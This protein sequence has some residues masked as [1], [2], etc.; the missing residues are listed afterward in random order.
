MSVQTAHRLQVTPSF[1]WNYLL[2]QPGNLASQARWPLLLFL[3]GSG[4]RG[5]DLELVKM[6]GLP[7]YIE[8]G[9]HFPFIIASPQ[10]PSDTRW[11]DHDAALVALLESLLTTLPVDVGRMYLTG[12][13]MGGE[14]TWYF[15]ALHPELFSAIAPICGR[16]PERSGWPGAVCSLIGVPVWC[17]HGMKD[18]RVSIDHSDLL[19]KT[20]KTCGGDVQYTIYPEADHNVWDRAYGGGSL[21]DWLLTHANA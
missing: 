17:F 15:A 13:S 12:L 8:Q 7:K 1:H 3:H 4:E 5:S 18:D 10:C 19:V 11:V 2:S 16:V 9:R 6:H 14:G 21:F 20:L